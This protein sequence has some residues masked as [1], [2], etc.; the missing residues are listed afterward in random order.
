MVGAGP[1][2]SPARKGEATDPFLGGGSVNYRYFGKIPNRGLSFPLERCP[3]RRARRSPTPNFQLWSPM[4]LRNSA[5]LRPETSCMRIR[6]NALTGN[7]PFRSL[8]IN[9][10]TSSSAR[11]RAA[12]FLRPRC[13]ISTFSKSQALNFIVCTGLSDGRLAFSWSTTFYCKL[14]INSPLTFKWT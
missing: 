6:T 4:S 5:M 10:A 12:S 11:E 13:L 1:S 2:V 9:G 3:M 7:R 14:F 8:L